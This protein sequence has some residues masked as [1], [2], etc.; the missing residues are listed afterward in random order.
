MTSHCSPMRASRPAYGRSTSATR[1]CATP[2]NRSRGRPE[3]R[4]VP[5]FLVAGGR[6]SGKTP[7]P[8]RRHPG[9][10]PGPG[11]RGPRLGARRRD[12]Q[13][14]RLPQQPRHPAGRHLCQRRQDPLQRGLRHPQR[15]PRGAQG[16]LQRPGQGCPLD[17][18]RPGRP[19]GRRAP[20]QAPDH[21][22]RHRLADRRRRRPPAEGVTRPRH[23]L[24]PPH[25]A[26]G[27]PHQPRRPGRGRPGQAGR[28][29]GPGRPRPGVRRGQRLPAGPGRQVPAA[30]RRRRDQHR[31]QG[32][33]QG[34]AQGQ[35]LLHRLG[36]RLP[37]PRRTTTPA[38]ACSCPWTA[39]SPRR[40]VGPRVGPGAH[41][42]YQ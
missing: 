1:P 5:Q 36:G 12:R 29:V 8:G 38:S 6:R 10:R 35:Y 39:D 40:R 13:G 18:Q 25:A 14:P 3:V 31:G 41:S 33:R 42:H 27:G 7:C 26:A 21:H 30:D 16:D 9:R 15:L 23:L 32:P 22:R 34:P 2:C 20:R 28:A 19:R 4:G 11:L 37:H 24:P 17:R